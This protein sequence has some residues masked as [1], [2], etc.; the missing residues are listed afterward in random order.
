M[1]AR[2]GIKIGAGGVELQ[3]LTEGSQD[4][5]ERLTVLEQQAEA[6]KTVLADL[7]ELLLPT[8]ES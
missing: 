6:A 5:E 3:D 2:F 1:L 4:L 8:E 7:E